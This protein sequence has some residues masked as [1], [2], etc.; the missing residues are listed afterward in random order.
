MNLT[1]VVS[2]LGI[3]IAYGFFDKKQKPPYAAYLGAGQE[4]FFGDN[5]IYS[6]VNDYT[7]E[8]YFVK[9]SAEKEEALETALL[10]N[11]YIYEKSEDVYVEDE[12]LFVIYYTLWRKSSAES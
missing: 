11:G 4:H 7:L 8:Y 5:T 12:H 9:K 10:D 6:K 2:G 3:P 1:D